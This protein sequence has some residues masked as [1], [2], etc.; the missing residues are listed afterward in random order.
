MRKFL[1]TFAFSSH[2]FV[3]AQTNHS[4]TLV[5]VKAAFQHAWR[6]YCTY[7]WGADALKPLSKQPH[8]W[9]AESLLMTPV[10]AFDTMILMD[11]KSEADSAKQLILS[12][13][14]F[15][16]NME[17]QVFEVTIRLLG[18][19]L[20]AYELDGDQRFLTL[21][22]DLADRLMP[23]FQSPTG[24]PY[25]YVHLQT[26]QTKDP[27]T[28]PAEAGTLLLEFGKL[29]QLT[30]QTKY[31]DAAL[32]AM[33]YL[34]KHKTKTGL[35]GTV[36]HAETGKWTNIE[37]HI[38]GMID[39]YYEYCYKGAL[40]FK[41]SSLLAMWNLH[42][43]AINQ[44][45]LVKQ[46]NGWWFTH[47]NGETGKEI[48]SAYGSLDAFYAGLLA[49]AGDLVTAEKNQEAN[50]YL[51]TKYGIEPEQF[52]FKA[53]S[54]IWGNYVLR[55]ENLESCFY[56]YRKTGKKQYLQMG[57]AMVNSLLKHCKTEAGFAQIKDVR[58]MVQED[59]MESFFFAETLKY[60]Y[61]LFAPAEKFD[62][63]KWVFNTE[64]HP[65]KILQ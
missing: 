28:N 8:N 14:S 30:H 29:S 49:Y 19:L 2:L 48:V 56:L 59:S 13:L 25:R 32:K 50:Y 27:Y 24:L 54:I 41:D 47:I 1:L 35:V 61:L 57:Q 21:A 46:E 44:H 43:K 22:Q 5:E 7:A 37:A 60:A 40:L 18:G 45:L 20:S 6:G 17:V 31:H 51:W 55:P 11:L 63:S 10:D 9:Y 34:F 62:L 3:F 39:S 36:I 52:N 33:Q 42:Q 23:A 12:R 15:D 65:F 53:D 16:K 26:G 4:S 64:A 58:T 38:S